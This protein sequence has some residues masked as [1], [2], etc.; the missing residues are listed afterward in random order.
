MSHYAVLHPGQGSQFVGMGRFLWE[1][2][3]LAREL[4]ARADAVLGMSL[5][6][7]CFTGPEA[8]LR[9]TE[10]AQPALFTVSSIS[11]MLLEDHHG[12][13]AA[14]AGH[15]A[16]EY[17][18]LVTAGALT[19]DDGLRLVRRRGE[20]MAEQCDRTS[21]TMAA[22]IGLPA[23]VVETL[24][25][26]ARAVG[27]VEIANENALTQI[28]VSGESVAVE[29]V[30]DLAE[31]YE[32]GVALQLDVAGAFHSRLMA[33]AARE[34]VVALDDVALRSASIP[35]VAN[36]TGDYVRT[37]AEIRHALIAQIDG[38]VRWHASLLRLAGDDVTRFVVADP[39]KTLASLV[40]ATV[41]KAS[42]LL[43]EDLLANHATGQTT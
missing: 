30:M 9:R 39:G 43:V 26:T 27:H 32:G 28:V 15:S 33:P 25:A 6:S 29:R 8:I 1:R 2:S 14:S 24:C 34:L 22:I 41:P 40:R 36:A 18:A 35:V 12:R 38:R 13:P 21:G 3:E 7:L 10:N 31:Q 42:A 20:L 16:G 37:P 5:T 19:F 17:A 23:P 11:A 4:F